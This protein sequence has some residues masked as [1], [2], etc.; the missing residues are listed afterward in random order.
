MARFE[1]I[2]LMGIVR[3]SGLGNTDYL[4][5]AMAQCVV[6]NIPQTLSSF[7]DSGHQVKQIADS[8]GPLYLCGISVAWWKTRFVRAETLPG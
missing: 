5:S 1:H 3:P 2:K 4:H 8:L 7:D 6:G